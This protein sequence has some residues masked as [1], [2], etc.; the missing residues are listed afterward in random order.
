MVYHTILSAK[1]ILGVSYALNGF[2]KPFQGIDAVQ[3]LNQPWAFLVFYRKI[4]YVK[5]RCPKGFCN[6]NFKQTDRAIFWDNVIRRIMLLIFAAQSLT[7]T[8]S[9]PIIKIVGHV[10]ASSSRMPETP[11]YRGRENGPSPP[12]VLLFQ[13]PLLFE[14]E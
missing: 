8:E 5:G 7:C 10:G 3:P 9:H 14:N 4:S 1:Q 12:F 11:Q 13:G 6:L 2:R